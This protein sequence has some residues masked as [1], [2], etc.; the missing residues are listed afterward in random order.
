MPWLYFNISIRITIANQ[1]EFY[2]AHSIK[3]ESSIE[4]LS[5]TAEIELPREFKNAL[6]KSESVSL[7]QK[8]LLDYIKPG[9]QIKVEFGYDDDLRTEFEGYITE[10]GAEIPTVLKCE[11]E[12][13]KLKKGK[14]INKTFP[15]IKLKQLLQTIAPGYEVDAPDM[16][17]GKMTIEQATPY[18]VLE[19]LKSDYGIR[20]FFKDGKLVAGMTVDIR[21]A[22]IHQFNFERNIRKS[23]DLVYRTKESRQLYIKA[24]SM[25]KGGKKKVT[26][27]FGTPGES[28]ISLHAP[29]NLSQAELKTWCEKYWASKVFD[30]FE[31]SIDGWCDPKTTI[32]STAEITD[33]N[34]PDGHRNGQ[35][36]IEGV[37]VEVNATAGIKRQNK[38]SF[39]I[40]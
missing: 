24:E 28:E 38:L 16:N 35:Y 14:L 22:E 8:R 7:E 23:S 37:T 26:Y 11:D 5:D 30:G 2:T 6:R 12:M 15:A 9:D 33:P 20:T 25:Q 31:G 34:Y 39:K 27:N 21:P 13:Y 32:G 19:R 1:L 4:K 29:I 18:R 40:K 3:I 10:V 36:F 17:L